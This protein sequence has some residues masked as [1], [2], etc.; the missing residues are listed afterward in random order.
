MATERHVQLF[1]ILP[2]PSC[3]FSAENEESEEKGKTKRKELKHDQV[4]TPRP[5]LC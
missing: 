4:I 1:M 2:K 5:P 3:G